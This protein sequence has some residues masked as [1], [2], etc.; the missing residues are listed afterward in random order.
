MV[1]S[2][3]FALQQAVYES[4]SADE[5]LTEMV[6]GVYD[7]LPAGTSQNTAFPYITIGD[8]VCR[9]WSTRT[10]SGSELTFNINCW[11]RQS[12]RKE[13]NEIMERVNYLLLQN[14][15]STQDHAVILVRFVSSQVTLEADGCTYKGVLQMRA[16]LQS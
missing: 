7:C 1:I 2:A 12:G 14:E 13:C 4:L 5:V 3:S 10:T 16:L 9:D 11:S 8:A 6:N 15:L